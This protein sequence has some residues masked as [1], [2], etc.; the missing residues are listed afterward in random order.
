MIALFF[1]CVPLVRA[2]E[3]KR[4]ITT[5]IYKQRIKDHP[6][7]LQGQRLLQQHAQQENARTASSNHITGQVYIIPIVFHII[8]NYGSE[9]ISDAQVQ[10]QVRILNDDFRKTSYDT[11]AIVSAFK[12]IMADCEIEFRL[13]QLDPDGHCTNGIDRI[14]S[15]LTYRADDE[16]KLNPWPNDM[17]LNVWVVSSLA[18][19]GAA[20]YAYYPGTA[21]PG[22]DGVIT[23]ADYVGSIGSGTLSRSRVLTHEI[24]HSLNLAHVWGDTNEPGVSCGDDW[25]GDTP[26]T[27]GWT[28]CNLSGATCGNVID[29]VQNYMEYSYCCKMFTEGQKD[30]MRATLTSFVDGRNNLWTIQN[31]AITG[32]DGSPAQVC[33]PIADFKVNNQTI[34][35]GGSVQFK[36]LSSNGHPTS[37]NW[38][39]PGGN[40]STSADSAPTIQYATAGGYDVSLTTGNSA[41]S[42]SKTKNAFIRVNGSSMLSVPYSEN[43]EAAGSFPLADGYVMNP[44]GGN[45]W[46][47]ITTVGSSGTACLRMN[48]YFGNQRGQIDEFVTPSFDFS[49]VTSVTLEFKLAYAELDTNHLDVLEVYASTNCGVTWLNRYSKTGQSLRTAPDNFSFYTPSPTEW[50]QESVNIISYH[51]KTNV[52]FKF[53]HISGGGNNLYLDDINING[54]ISGVHENTMEASLLT[55]YPNP[56]SGNFLV[57]FKLDKAQKVNLKVVDALGREVKMLANAIMQPGEH[58]YSTDKKLDAG[59]YFVTL[60]RDGKSTTRKILITEN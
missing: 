45:T 11:A 19:A 58:R 32:T 38:N 16:S 37:W 9:N 4:C 48:N 14:P 40:P 54:I 23:L 28:N 53:R 5:E 6:E 18:W 34:C 41:G 55:I 7:I 25:V 15:M 51:N 29:N 2:Q 43:F 26:I 33:A 30:R 21:P 31:Q 44:D 20:A 35:E 36:D 3:L 57:T 24:G 52:R 12:P 49:N 8:H 1:L 46:E 27:S 50:R 47:R 60:E 56:T 17:Y 59:I 13:A 10:D 39:F 22:A 42:D